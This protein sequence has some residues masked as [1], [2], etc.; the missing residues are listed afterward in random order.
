MFVDPGETLLNYREN[1]SKEILQNQMGCCTR[2]DTES[3]FGS[4]YGNH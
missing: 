2:C 3:G 4:P 1:Y